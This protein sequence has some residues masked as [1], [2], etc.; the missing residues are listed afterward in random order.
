MW[1]AVALVGIIT[2]LIYY[3]TRPPKDFWGKYGVR[4]VNDTTFNDKISILLGRKTVMDIDELTYKSLASTQEK[5]CGLVEMQGQTVL[6]RDLDMVKRVMIKDFE[7][8]TDKRLAVSSE[9]QP[10]IRKFLINLQGEEWKNVRSSLSPTFT[11]TKIKHMMEYFNKISNEWVDHLKTKIKNSSEDSIVINV[12][13]EARHFTVDIISSS[14]FGMESQAISNP[15][16][17]FRTMTDRLSSLHFLQILKYLLMMFSPWIV[18]FFGIKV[19]DDTALT[20]FE[21]ILSQGMKSRMSGETKRNDF[22]QLIA[23]VRKGELKAHASDELSTFE[24]DAKLKDD[25]KATKRKDVLKDDLIAYAQLLQF[26]FAGFSTVSNTLSFALYA[27]ALNPDVQEKL[28]KEVDS[29]LFKDGNDKELDYDE[30][31]ALVYMDMFVCELLRK[32]P[33]VGRIERICVKEYHEPES[34][35]KVPRGSY[36]FAPIQAIHN[37]PQYYEHPEKFYPEHFTPEKKAERKQYAYMPFGIGPRSCIG[38]RFALVVSKAAIAQLV[39]FFIIE[40][41]PKTPVPMQIKPIGIAIQA[42]DNLE[43]KLRLRK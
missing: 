43:L 7:Y 24:K 39:R 40:P 10:I 23:E 33:P 4:Q 6:L 2:F 30:L 27:M 29:K 41:T 15:D 17:V 26:F 38:M 19:M 35:L 36:A 31:N 32:L 13:E 18:N 25:E 16:S 11:T 1:V 34:G 20:F 5:F 8:F 3:L 21:N 22:L 28:R 9:N 14:A 37:D 12:G 42:P